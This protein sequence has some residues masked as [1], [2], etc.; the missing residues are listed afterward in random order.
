MPFHGMTSLKFNHGIGQT[1]RT[2][3]A[4]VSLIYQTRHR[5]IVLSIPQ[6]TYCLRFTE[7]YYI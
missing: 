2:T 4:W 5:H 6:R 3:F 1:I 7:P